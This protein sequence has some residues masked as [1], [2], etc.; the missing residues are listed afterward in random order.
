MPSVCIMGNGGEFRNPLV[1]GYLKEAEW[2]SGTQP[3]TISTAM[4]GWSGNTEHKK[5]Y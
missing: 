3:P 1:S 5:E 2:M 4:D